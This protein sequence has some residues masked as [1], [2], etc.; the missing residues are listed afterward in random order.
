MNEIKKRVAWDDLAAFLVV[1]QTGG[2]SAAARQIGSS[3]AT[4]GRRMHALERALSR[5][6]FIRRTHGYEL[7]EAGQALLCDIDAIAGRIEKIT[8]RRAGN[9]LPLVKLSAGTWTAL[10]LAKHAAN[11]T[12]H[13]A[14]IRLRFVASEDMLSINRREAVIGIR[15]SRPYQAALAGR[16]LKQVN[17]AS[18]AAPGAPAKWIAV[19]ANTPSAR[20]LSTNLEADILHEVSNPRLALDMAQ[21]GAGRIVL[22][23]FVGD[24]EPGLERI[25]HNIHELTHDQ[26]LV[27]HDDDRYLPEV[28]RCID[29][30]AGILGRIK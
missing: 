8:A 6:L 10:L 11:I 2:L 27:T 20:W 30:I 15:N 25:G 24:S 26:W 5:E 22:P 14:D 18:Y 28:R 3:A 21:S 16:K 1:A 19:N 13:P 17:F 12:G 7:T 23:T 4:L 9:S 29:R